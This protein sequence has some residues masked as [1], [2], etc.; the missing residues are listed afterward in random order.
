[1]GA[2]S[3][4]CRQHEFHGGLKFSHVF[5]EGHGARFALGQGARFA[6]D[7]GHTRGSRMRSVNGPC[8]ISYL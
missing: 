4:F 2:T 3:E 7:P 5:V 1:M 6:I 8:K